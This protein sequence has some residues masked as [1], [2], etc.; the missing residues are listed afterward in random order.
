[1]APRHVPSLFRCQG[2]GTAIDGSDSPR[3]PSTFPLP[4][5]AAG[6][7]IP[8]G[9]KPLAQECTT[10]PIRRLSTVATVVLRSRIVK[11]SAMATVDFPR[12]V[13][14]ESELLFLCSSGGH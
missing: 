3:T 2:M 13:S 7:S 1:M 9:C 6:Q 10:A 5:C 12:S 11:R 8:D 14:Y 4:T